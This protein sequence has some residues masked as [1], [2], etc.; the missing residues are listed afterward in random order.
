MAGRSHLLLGGPLLAL[1]VLAATTA[2]AQ[3]CPPPPVVDV[4]ALCSQEPARGAIGCSMYRL[5]NNATLSPAIFPPL[6]ES[7][8]F[9]SSLCSDDA[10]ISA[11]A[12]CAQLQASYASEAQFRSCLRPYAAASTARALNLTLTACDDMDGM[13]MAGCKECTRESCPDPFLYYAL[14]CVDM[15]MGQC[16]PWRAFCSRDAAPIGRAAAVLCLF[17]TTGIVAPPR[18]SSPP[19]PT[20]AVTPSPSPADAL[21]PSPMPA[22]TPTPTPTPSPAALDA[23]ITSPAM[24][25]CAGYEY[26]ATSIAADLAGLCT[27]MP[28]MPGCSIRAACQAGKVTGDFC[29]P[30]NLLASICIDMPSMGQCKNYNRLCANGTAVAQCSALPGIPGLPSTRQAQQATDA[31]CGSMYMWQCDECSSLS[32]KDYL[33]SITSMC[34][35]MPYMVGCDVFASWCAASSAWQGVNGSDVSSFC[36]GASVYGGSTSSSS[37]P[38]M[39]MF[40]HQR[41]GELI[42]FREW[43]PKTTGQAVGSCFAI[44]GMG[45][46]AVALRTLKTILGLAAAVGRLGP[47]LTPG[48]RGG[49]LWW[50]PTGGQSLLNVINA[51]I[52]MLV[53]TL[54]LFTM[55]VAMTFNGAYFA[56]VVAGYMLGALF[57]GH[58]GEAYKRRLQEELSAA[59][60]PA[61]PILSNADPKS[62]EK[63]SQT[64]VALKRLQ[65]SSED[66]IAS[67]CQV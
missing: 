44:I 12:G 16:D 8:R 55:L 62:G 49:R 54:D 32:C 25:T 61:A 42:L 38:S 34:T 36:A 45:F 60:D 24:P 33:G 58:L 18:P 27:S 50:C 6:C 5:C 52:T 35:E 1:V 41:V 14:G 11:A 3:D 29:A 46:T 53:T 40:F 56:A 4:A 23:C 28:Y 13:P 48:S 51:F 9:V 19:P 2:L 66:E 7:W 57:L 26:P 21:S 47:L 67:C 17:N 59:G 20:V 15:D 22:P 31:M 39:L 30:M 37:I 63:Q 65:D 10:A 64:A 43:L